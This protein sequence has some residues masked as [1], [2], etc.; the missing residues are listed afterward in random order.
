MKK[1]ILWIV[2]MTT[3]YSLKGFLLQIFIL[4]MLFA[5]VPVEGQELKDIRITLDAK[6]VTLESAFKIIEKQSN[7]K[8]FYIESE[9]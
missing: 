1:N 5:Y 4:N 3:I 8:F 9:V 2:K 6:N 7:L